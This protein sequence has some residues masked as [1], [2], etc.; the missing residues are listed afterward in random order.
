MEIGA[1]NDARI[2]PF[3]EDGESS[4]HLWQEIGR[5]AFL[6]QRSQTVKFG[7][8]PRSENA[9]M[10]SESLVRNQAAENPRFPPQCKSA[11]G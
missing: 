4:C 8:V 7:G 9:G 3:T 5:G 2:K 1:E 10:S 6:V 11:E